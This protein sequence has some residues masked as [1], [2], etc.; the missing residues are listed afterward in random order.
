MAEQPRFQML[1]ADGTKRVIRR[2]LEPKMFRIIER[3][4][5]LDRA[6]AERILL[7]GKPI[8]HP[9]ATFRKLKGVD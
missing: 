7:S 3:L 1:P 2:A 4:T 6:I 5:G 8:E 9:T